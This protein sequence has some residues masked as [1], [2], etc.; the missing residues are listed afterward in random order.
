MNLFFNQVKVSLFGALL[1]MHKECLNIGHGYG[2]NVGC[3]R[4]C[5]NW[6]GVDGECGGALSI[7]CALVTKHQINLI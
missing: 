3:G 2:C 1:L 6:C 7:L 5:G 4:S